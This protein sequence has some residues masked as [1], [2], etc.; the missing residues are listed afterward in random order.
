MNKSPALEFLDTIS[1][2]EDAEKF[3]ITCYLTLQLIS[4]LAK[5]K[6]D[7]SS[8]ELYEEEAQFLGFLRK[9]QAPELAEVF[10]KVQKVINEAVHLNMDKKSAFLSINNIVKAAA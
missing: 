6:V 9:L 3:H 2:K 8:V 7:R 1:R 10:S 5:A 4:R